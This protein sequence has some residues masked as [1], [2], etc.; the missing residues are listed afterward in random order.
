LY[1]FVK[2]VLFFG[3]GPGLVPVP[4]KNGGPG[5]GP[6]SKFG[7]GGTL[8]IASSRRAESKY[9]I[10]SS[11]TPGGYIFRSSKNGQNV[12]AIFFTGNAIENA[13]KKARAH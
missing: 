6:G 8:P 3:P 4:V 1:S 9:R 12:S 13:I 11:I 10:S 2:N 5:P 7:P